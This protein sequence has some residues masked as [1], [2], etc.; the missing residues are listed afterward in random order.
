[1]TP[2]YCQEEYT[3]PEQDAMLAGAGEE[4]KFIKCIDDIIGKD[5]L[6]S[7]VEQA[8]GQDMTYLRELGVCAKVDEHAAVAKYNVIPNRHKVDRHRHSI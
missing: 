8:R 1:M 2:K 7:A 3:K 5:L 6:P 4:D